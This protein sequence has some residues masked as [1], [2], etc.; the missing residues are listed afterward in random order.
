LFNYVKYWTDFNTFQGG[1]SIR[2]LNE[3]W[4]PG[5]TNATLPI[6]DENDAFSSQP[7]SY[8]VEDGTYLRIKNL[9]LAYRLPQKMVSSYGLSNV[10]FYIQAQNAFT[11]TKYKGL[12][13]EVAVR[14][15]ANEFGIDEGILPASR[16][17]LFGVNLGF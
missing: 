8:Y 5:K 4:V 14:G 15:N 1:R 13:P 6:L 12:D 11:F 10:R 3:S 9:Q 16:T 2:I 7:S 17:F